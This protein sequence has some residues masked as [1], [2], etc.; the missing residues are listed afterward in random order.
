[1]LRV[2]QR[3]IEQIVQQE[4]HA[5]GL[6]VDNVMTPPLLGVRGVGCFEI[7]AAC[8]IGASGL[9][10]SCASVARK[11]VLAVVGFYARQASARSRFMI[12]CAR[13]SPPAFDR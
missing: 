13:P 3:D 11:F 2:I 7:S 12:S 8:R 10:S 9:R 6:P 5:A 1:M 4:G